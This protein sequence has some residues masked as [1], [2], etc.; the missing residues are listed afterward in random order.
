MFQQCQSEIRI[1]PQ[2]NIGYT[3]TIGFG[4]HIREASGAA[5]ETEAMCNALA[6]A[7]HIQECVTCVSWSSN[8]HGNH[9]GDERVAVT[10]YVSVNGVQSSGRCN[11]S[12]RHYAIACALYDAIVDGC[13]R[14]DVRPCAVLTDAG[15]AAGEQAAPAA[16]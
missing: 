6:R 3:A 16:A 4:K 15:N 12:D 7:M 10:V 5:T 14:A 9:E 1:E 13:L 8:T 2:V 11:A